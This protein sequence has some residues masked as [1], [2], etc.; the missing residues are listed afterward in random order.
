MVG[1]GAV[2]TIVGVVVGVTSGVAVGTGAAATNVMRSKVGLGVCA[3]LGLAAARQ[4]NAM[5]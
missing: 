5:I 2:G 4:H 3:S 1:V